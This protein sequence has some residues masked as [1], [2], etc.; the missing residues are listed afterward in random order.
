[1]GRVHDYSDNYV[2]N[3]VPSPQSSF[4]S[5]CLV[6]SL[7][8]LSSSNQSQS[9]TSLHVS[10]ML[11]SLSGLKL[12]GYGMGILGKNEEAE[13]KPVST[14]T[15]M[16][17]TAISHLMVSHNHEFKLSPP[18]LLYFHW[19]TIIVVFLSGVPP[20]T[21][22]FLVLSSMPPRCVWCHSVSPG[23]SLMHALQHYSG[24]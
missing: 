20:T 16:L 17:S 15:S 23:L 22:P 1:M 6:H 5:T 10:P 9:P 7:P 13:R 19:K 11:W 4:A 3:I 18:H 2:H 12:N 14:P 24:R 8:V 21:L